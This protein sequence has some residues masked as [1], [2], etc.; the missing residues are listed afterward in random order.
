MLAIFVERA[1]AFEDLLVLLI[2]V[3][4]GARFINGVDDVV[5]SA[6]VILTR[7]GPFR[8]IM[9]TVPMV[10][11][12]VVVASVVGLLVATASCAMSAR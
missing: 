10:T 11:T 4:L 1:W 8:P 9:A 2:I 5:W 7:F 3:A 12:T 6:A